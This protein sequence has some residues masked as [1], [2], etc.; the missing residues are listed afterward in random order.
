MKSR[1]AGTLLFLMRE[2]ALGVRVTAILPQSFTKEPSIGITACIEA[3]RAALE[4]LASTRAPWPSAGSPVRALEPRLGRA[5]AG[6]GQPVRSMVES[7]LQRGSSS[8][9]PT[10]GLPDNSP[11]ES[12]AVQ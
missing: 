4:A 3:T 5:R 7:S 10:D 12:V 8:Q 1:I 6:L 9:T 2:A 11:M